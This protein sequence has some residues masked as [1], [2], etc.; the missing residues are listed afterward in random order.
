MVTVPVLVV[1][2]AGNVRILFVLSV[3][4]PATAGETASADTVTVNAE[5]TACS[6]VAVTVL[7]LEEPLS[8][9]ESGVSTSV[10]TGAVSVRHTMTLSPSR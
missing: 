2:F 5:S 8:E 4:S 1:E 7:E 9:I 10:T 3:K 6:R